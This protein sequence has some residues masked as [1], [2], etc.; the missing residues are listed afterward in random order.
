MTR[1]SV[2]QL[3][4]AALFFLVIDL[5]DPMGVSAQRYN[6]SLE[7]QLI[8][9]AAGYQGRGDLAEAERVLRVVLSANPT[10]DVGLLAMERVFG[11]QGSLE[12][13][14]PLIDNYLKND[15]RATVARG[16]ELEVYQN[17]DEL[18]RLHESAEEWLAIAGNSAEPYR[19]V[20]QVFLEVYGRQEALEVLRRGEEALVD[21][22]NFPLG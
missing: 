1:T 18:G 8:R 15:P 22:P 9:E 10:S 14:L 17:L 4:M 13:I 19:R 11:E 12:K 3:C 21:L 20:S 2:F 16:L 7:R 6:P 5:F